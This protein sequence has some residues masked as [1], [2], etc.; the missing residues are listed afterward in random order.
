MV[1]FP[2]AFYLLPL[3]FEGAPKVSAGILVGLM[4]TQIVAK[5]LYEIIALPLTVRVVKFVKK[6]EGV[7]VYDDAVSYNPLN[8]RDI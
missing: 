7:D 8:V 1:F 2:L 4:S 6:Y 5:T 3:L